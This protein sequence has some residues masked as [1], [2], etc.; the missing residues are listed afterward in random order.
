MSLTLD[1]HDYP[2]ACPGRQLPNITLTPLPVEHTPDLHLLEWEG[3]GLCIMITPDRLRQLA[4]LIAAKI[5]PV[6]P[7]PPEEPAPPCAEECMDAE[8]TF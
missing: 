1:F 6:A 2:K 7:Q 5:P 3:S 8:V 4:A